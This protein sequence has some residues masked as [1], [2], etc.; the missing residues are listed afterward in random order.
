M[1]KAESDG[2]VPALREAIRRASLVGSALR[3]RIGVIGVLAAAGWAIASNAWFPAWFAACH[4]D[5]PLIQSN[6]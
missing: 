5:R 3:L 1:A 4:Q 2:Q 6:G